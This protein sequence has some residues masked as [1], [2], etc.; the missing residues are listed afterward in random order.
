MGS[1][2]AASEF[3]QDLSAWNVDNVMHC[4]E[5]SID[6]PQWVL[7]KPTFMNCDPN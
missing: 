4:S 3:N 1:M 7:P 2:F 6:T 5:F